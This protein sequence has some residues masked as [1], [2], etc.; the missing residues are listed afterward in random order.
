MCAVTPRTQ[1]TLI[2]HVLDQ[3]EQT[4][5]SAEELLAN[6]RSG[7]NHQFLVFAIYQSAHALDQQAFSV[8]FEDGIPL[9]SPQS[10]DDV[11]ASAAERGFQFL[12]DLSIAAHRAVEAL[13]IAVDDKNQVVEL[14]ARS[15]SDRPERFR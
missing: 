9:A 1:R 10:L 14:L 4:R 6:I 15:Q 7:G 2:G 5:I 12:N 11:P 3:L 8:T 13:Q